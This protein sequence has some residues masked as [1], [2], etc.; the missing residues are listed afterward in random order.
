MKA[1]YLSIFLLLF[2]FNSIGQNILYVDS[3][4]T[5]LDDG[6]T[7]ANAYNDLQDALESAQPGEQIWVAKGRYIATKGVNDNPASYV[8]MV[9]TMRAG[10]KIYGGFKGHENHLRQRKW[11][12]NKTALQGFSHPN[13]SS[14]NVIVAQYLDSTAAL[15]GFYI[16]KAKNIGAFTGGGIV[17][18]YSNA[19]LTNLVVQDNYSGQGAGIGLTQSSP[20]ISN[21]TI[22]NNNSLF[23]GGG[24][25]IDGGSPTILNC[26]IADNYAANQGLGVFMKNTTARIINTTITGNTGP[27]RIPPYSAIAMSTNS[28]PAI[29]NTIIE[30]GL[31]K[32]PVSGISPTFHH[33]IV[34]MSG[35]S[36]N[37][38]TYYGTD[39]GGNL[40]VPLIYADSANG[41]YRLMEC[42]PGLD[43]G[44][45]NLLPKDQYDLDFDGITNELFPYDIEGKPRIV[46]GKVDIGAYEGPF[47]YDTVV[48]KLCVGSSIKL[49]DST[50]TQT[51]VY[52][53]RYSRGAGLCDSVLHFNVVTKITGQVQLDSANNTLI[54]V[55]SNATYQWYDCTNLYALPA[56]T[57]QSFT[58][59]IQST[60]SV[61]VTKDGCTDTSACM[62]VNKVS[63]NEPYK[64]LSLTVYP[65]PS[66]GIYKIQM[67]KAVGEIKLTVLDLNG[68]VILE[69]Q[70][71]SKVEQIDLS[72][73]PAGIYILQLSSTEIGTVS[74]RLVRE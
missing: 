47:G 13:V 69:K 40:D 67:S 41:D 52:T 4:A 42:S 30:G 24:I 17:Y 59:W 74:K 66:N 9:F 64:P 2:S 37:W 6:T 51:G 71:N 46:N 58:P 55:D 29:L 18:I 7:W 60:Y 33:S 23:F 38:N 5:G 62:V 28:S 65:N 21:V 11:K 49:E 73:K 1:L 45:A 53:F 39:A 32:Y 44:I 15:D 26:L 43:S 68:K 48:V 72:D 8:D 50:I 27:G 31:Y 36:S 10:V 25:Y 12:E 56:D 14:K 70:S 54:A 63:L 20:L 57:N 34:E 35:G 3:A 61:I 16:E 19:R 22:I